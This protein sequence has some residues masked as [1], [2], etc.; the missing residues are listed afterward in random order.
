MLWRTETFLICKHFCQANR[1]IF[2]S[3]STSIIH[4]EHPLLPRTLPENGTLP[5]CSYATARLRQF[6]FAV[7]LRDRFGARCRKL[8][9]HL[10]LASALNRP[11]RHYQQPRPMFSV[12]SIVNL[13][14]TWIHPLLR[15]RLF[16]QNQNNLQPL[17][18]S[19]QSHK[20]PRVVL[21]KR[22]HHHSTRA[23][24]SPR[25]LHMKPTFVF[26]MAL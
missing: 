15:Q 3:Y 2:P 13:C 17:R 20:L 12:S 14:S 19:L 23:C 22:S 21:T 7:R 8:F 18:Q 11:L 16:P 1:L 26:Q 9:N 6:S 25:H 24:H 5:N 4:E 10:P